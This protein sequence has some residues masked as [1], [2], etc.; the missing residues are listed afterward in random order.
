VLL[1][2]GGTVS[3]QQQALI[4]RGVFRTGHRLMGVPGELLRS[5]FDFL[6]RL[7]LNPQLPKQ[8]GELIH[9]VTDGLRDRAPSGMAGD[10]FVTK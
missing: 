1:G 10:Q 4:P 8:E 6:Q 2:G 5:Q 3:R 7:R 9:V